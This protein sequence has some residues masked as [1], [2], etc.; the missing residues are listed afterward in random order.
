MKLLGG[1]AFAKLGVIHY[2]GRG[3]PLKETK[4]VARVLSCSLG[5]PRI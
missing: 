1:N 3:G 2:E 5:S 4:T